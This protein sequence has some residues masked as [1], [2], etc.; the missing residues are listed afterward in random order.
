[1]LGSARISLSRR[2]VRLYPGFSPYGSPHFGADPDSY[3]CGLPFPKH[4]EAGHIGWGKPAARFSLDNVQVM[5]LKECEEWW[6]IYKMGFYYPPNHY[7]SKNSGTYTLLYVLHR[8]Y[9]VASPEVLDCVA[10]V[11]LVGHFHMG[12]C[13][14]NQCACKSSFRRSNKCKGTRTPPS[15]ELPAFTMV[16]WSSVVVLLAISGIHRHFAAALKPDS[17]RLADPEKQGP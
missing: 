7:S 10:L 6:F 3:F 14:R 2:S 9:M 12:S 16:L 1:M 4:G 5:W 13:I 11:G 17:R 8:C 15:H